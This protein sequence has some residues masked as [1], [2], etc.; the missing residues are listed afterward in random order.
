MGVSNFRN[1][2]IVAALGLGTSA[3]TTMTIPTGGACIEGSGVVAPLGLGGVHK[4]RYNSQCGQT[5]AANSM[6][7]SQDPGVRAVGMLTAGGNDPTIK[8]NMNRVNG[9]LA[10]TGTTQYRVQRNPD[11]SAKLEGT[12]VITVPQPS[13]QATPTPQP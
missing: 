6:I 9:A 8:E 4:Q 5:M 13:A 11:G 7:Q 2:M 3:C 10:N 12:P 1:A